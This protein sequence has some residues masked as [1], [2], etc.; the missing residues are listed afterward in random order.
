MAITKY[1][2]GSDLTILNTLYRKPTKDDNTK[3]W[4]KGDITVIY[5]DNVSGRKGHS[6]IQNP[7]YHYY[8]TKPVVNTDYQHL[9]I[10]KDNVDE[11]IAPYN[12]V[13]KDIAQRTG[14][15]EFY[16]ENLKCGNKAANRQLHTLPCVYNSDSDISDHYRAL[17]GRQYKNQSFAVT[18]SFIDIEV[19]GRYAFSDFPELG[20]CPVNATTFI[21]IK[22]QT[23]NV[24]L[25]RDPKNPL[26][27]EF[28][29]NVKNGKTFAAFNK[30]MKD[31][32]VNS[33]T[34]SKRDDML[35]KYNEINLD[36][37][38]LIFNFYDI[39]I[40]LIAA[41]FE[42]I[43]KLQP[44]FVL[45]WNMAFDIP[46]LIERIKR[47]GYDPAE[48]MS[49]PEFEHKMA[50]Y[51]IDTRHKN[52]YELRGD[53][54]NISAYSVYVDQLIQFASRRKGQAAFPNFKLDTAGE[55]IAGVRKLNWSHIVS[56]LQDLPQVDYQTFVFY[57]IMDVIVQVFIEHSCQDVEYLFTSAVN[58]D[59]KYS[60]CH[61][62]TV[63]LVNKFRKFCYERGYIVGN[64]C[65]FDNESIKYLGALVGKP[66]HNTDY[67]KIHQ[68][69]EILNC[70]RNLDDFD[71]KSLYPSIARQHNT[72]PNE[73]I[74]RVIINN[75]IYDGENPFMQEQYNRGG[76]FIEDYCTNNP[77]EFCSR[78]LHL[79]GMRDLI[80]DV[81][82]YMT[83][84]NVTNPSY[85][86][87]MRPFVMLAENGE[88]NKPEKQ[89]TIRP[90]VIHG[91]TGFIN[92]AVTQAGGM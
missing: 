59:T 92:N 70:F 37:F 68:N 18:K 55:L 69:G 3:K 39:E 82:E 13:L 67:G 56:K 30:F 91:N 71:F 17:F 72:A 44:D 80:S 73:I 40:V 6:Y 33:Y 1:P 31:H 88:Y 10:S 21:D 45:A 66:Y 42:L 24:F 5:K 47:L 26:C 29:E 78:W 61:R 63:Y 15:S 22:S 76:A 28:E 81:N 65:N 60:K 2:E 7:D 4:S 36:A 9:Y 41:I 51:Y 87:Y 48:I 8:M 74:G 19:D 52:E 85:D 20:E 86:G 25:L 64:N 11:Y 14:N 46:Y 79:A 84:V 77:I 75:Q 83:K 27:A 90:F 38:E 23:I 32:I 43:N 57:N 53:Y 54:Y 50:D 34:G 12:D 58:N 89:K 35:K 16:Y 62:Q 49:H